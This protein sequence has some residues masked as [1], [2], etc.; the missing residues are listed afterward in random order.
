MRRSSVFCAIHAAA[1]LLACAEADRSAD[2]AVAALPTT[3]VF[4][5]RAAEAGLDFVHRN[6]AVGDYNYPE[7]LV[8]GAALLDFDDDGLL[9]VYLVQSGPVPGTPE[10]ATSAGPVANRPGNRLY[11]NLGDGAFGDVTDTAGVGDTGYGAGATA[12]D[13][14]RDGLVDLYVTNVGPNRL[15]RNLGG[16]TFEDA[17]ERAGVG[18]PAWSSSSVFFDYDGD[19]DMDLDSFVANYVVWSAAA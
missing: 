4:V 8:G 7:L 18:D 15:Y 3:P 12:A 10:A 2:A 16:G 14:D 11:R 19:L 13:Y 1:V 6:G 17:T 9:D 5:E